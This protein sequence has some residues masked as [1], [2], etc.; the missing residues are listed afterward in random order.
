VGRHV[1]TWTY[2]PDPARARL[3]LHYWAFIFPATLDWVGCSCRLLQ[4]GDPSIPT[5][6]P[7]LHRAARRL[8]RSRRP[9]LTEGRRRRTLPLH[10]DRL[11]MNLLSASLSTSTALPCVQ[12]TAFPIRKL[13]VNSQF[14]LPR[15]PLSRFVCTS[16]VGASWSLDRRSTRG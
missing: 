11:M 2:S 7:P 5:P 6:P 8:R 3:P 14:L 12:L 13:P 10:A 1:G 15:S 9:V 16:I 4:A